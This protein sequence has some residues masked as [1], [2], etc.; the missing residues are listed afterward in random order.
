MMQQKN[1]QDIF[2]ILS[3]N[4]TEYALDSLNISFPTILKHGQ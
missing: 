3:Y 1:N 4:Y 2:E